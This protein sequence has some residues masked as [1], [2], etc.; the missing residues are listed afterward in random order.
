M[1]L[2]GNFKRE[3]CKLRSSGETV[4][5]GGRVSNDRGRVTPQEPRR[6]GLDDM[7]VDVMSELTSLGGAFPVVKCDL[8]GISLKVY[9]NAPH[10]VREIIVRAQEFRDA[11]GVTFEDERLSWG[12]ILDRST[13]VARELSNTLQVRKGDRVAIA[14]RNYPEFVVSFISTM[15]IG[16][17]SVPLNAW[18]TG[19]E[20]AYALN[21]C[22]ARILIADHERVASLEGQR[23]STPELKNVVSVRSPNSTGDLRFE[24][25][26]ATG[27]GGFDYHDVSIDPE[28]VATILYTSGTTG[29]PKGAVSTHRNHV[30]NFMNM[31]YFRAQERELS[32]RRHGAAPQPSAPPATLLTGPLFHIGSLPNVYVAANQGLHL[33]MMYKWDP[34]RALELIERE[35]VTA[36]GGV[37]MVVRQLLDAA[38]NSTRDLSSLVSLGTGGAQVT[39]EIVGRIRTVFGGRVGTGTSYGMTEA[40]SAMV[41]IGSDDLFAHPLAAGW[42][43]PTSEVRVVDADGR[44]VDTGET[45]EAWFRGPNVCRRYWNR[46]SESFR[47]DGWYCSG[48]L[49]KV[50]DEGLVYIVDRIKDV[51]IRAGENVFSGEVEEAIA[52]IHGVEDVAVFG[53]PHDLWG[54]EVCAVV[55]VA[56]GVSINESDVRNSVAATLARFKIP[57]TVVVRDEALPRN[58]SG[59][60]LKRELRRQFLESVG[61]SR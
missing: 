56:P 13:V 39:S 3:D 32:I 37:P 6:G 28:D 41:A 19:T 26:L 30:S 21:D 58:A 59:K 27:G 42:P 10:D 12:E 43:Y 52:K 49:V 8:G 23:Q 46:E 55:K 20:L 4:R 22:G 2:R 53:I 47:A 38:S 54:E 24:D 15:L 7:R 36:T 48:D 45:G 44:D 14:M 9:Q 61:S 51:V 33:V 29:R 31:N 40:T 11:P 60:I 34:E 25:L 17:V 57:T 50:D 1:N 16:G 18:W 35:R 5:F